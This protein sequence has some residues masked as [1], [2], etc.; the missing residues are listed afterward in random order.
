[1]TTDRRVG[2]EQGL[3][4]SASPTRPS[5]L[6]A[7]A[8]TTDR[9]VGIEQG[10]QA[11]ASP[12]RPSRVRAAAM[13]TDRRVGIEQGL[14]R[15][16]HRRVH[17]ERG[18]RASGSP[19]RP[20]RARAAAMSLAGAPLSNE[21]RGPRQLRRAGVGLR[22]GG[23]ALRCAGDEAGQGDL[24]NRGA[25]THVSCPGRSGPWRLEVDDRARFHAIAR[26][27]ALEC[28]AILDV[29]SVL[30]AAKPGDAKSLLTRVVAMLTKM[31]R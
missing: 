8:M 31:C 2:I 27:S 10:L 14:R 13:T 9:R 26:G 5:R 19:A 12:T 28:G 7:A 1:M 4:A 11:S 6:R 30:G 25:W 21:G 3:Q 24:E 15:Q 18:P 20:S 29:L 16:A 22:R 23:E 17:I